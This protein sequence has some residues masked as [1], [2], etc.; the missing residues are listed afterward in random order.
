MAHVLRNDQVNKV[1]NAYV[2][3]K[4]NTAW[5]DTVL[6]L[7]PSSLMLRVKSVECNAQSNLILRVKSVECNAQSSL[8]LRVKSVECSAQSSLM[9]RVKPRRK[10]PNLKS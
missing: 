6:T 9:S 4:T 2:I 3:N 5:K 10:F 1:I 7:G 8:M